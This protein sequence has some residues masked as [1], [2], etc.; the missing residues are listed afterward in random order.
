MVVEILAYSLSRKVTYILEKEIHTTSDGREDTVYH[1]P[2]PYQYKYDINQI[3]TCNNS[4][5]LLIFVTSAPYK[6]VFRDAIRSSWASKN[7]TAKYNTKVLFLFGWDVDK[8]NNNLVEEES[9][10]YQ[11]IVRAN[12]VDKYENLTLKSLAMLNWVLEYCRTARFL[13]KS[14]DDLYINLPVMLSEL[15]KYETSQHKFVLGRIHPV[16]PVPRSNDENC[17]EKWMMSREEYPDNLYPEYIIG[18]A[19]A[20]SVST[21]SDLHVASM[22]VRFVRIEDVFITGLCAD[23]AG[24][25]RIEIKCLRS[26]RSCKLRQHACSEH[27]LKPIQISFLHKTVIKG[28]TLC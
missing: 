11:D 12:F 19:Y 20:M 28:T 21:V 15:Q 2:L 17:E 25:P 23:K 8:V 24:I 1:G 13:V 22:K 3:H 14:D 18:C 4:L 5:E 27:K 6:T 7:F 10:Q 16:A 26:T 9:K